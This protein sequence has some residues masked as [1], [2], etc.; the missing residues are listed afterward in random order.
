[1]NRVKLGKIDAG[2]ARELT[3]RFWFAKFRWI[4][5]LV[6]IPFLIVLAFLIWQNSVRQNEW[7]PERKQQFVMG[8]G[9]MGREFKAE[10]FREIVEKVGKA[11]KIFEED[12]RTVKNVFLSKD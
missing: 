9:Q 1:M 6:Y 5:F 3:E 2:K 10:V 7:S 12:G 11:E 8:S 4:Y